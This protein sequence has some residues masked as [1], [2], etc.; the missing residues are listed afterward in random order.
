MAAIATVCCNNALSIGLLE[1]LFECHRNHLGEADADKTT[2]GHSVSVVNQRH[3]L[4]GAKDLVIVAHPHN[5]CQRAS[6]SSADH[7]CSGQ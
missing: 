5:L 6:M 3:S 1:A 7:G 4:G 2:D